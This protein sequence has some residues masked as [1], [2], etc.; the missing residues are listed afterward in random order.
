MQETELKDESGKTLSV[1]RE[2]PGE[3]VCG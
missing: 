1:D 3:I 2:Y